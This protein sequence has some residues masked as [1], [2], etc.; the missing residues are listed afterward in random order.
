MRQ[1][2]SLTLVVCLATAATVVIAADAP[3]ITTKQVM[4]TAM[5]G[6]LLK[7]VAGGSASAEE[8]AKLVKLL[9]ALAANKPKK[10]EAESW[11]AKTGALVKA[12]KA[13]DLAGL[14]T[15]GNCAKCHKAHK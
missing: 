2:L 1:L 13:G 15:A 11:K 6:G 8:K 3:K 10:G 14:K 12:A 9:E 7:K 5:K 4:K